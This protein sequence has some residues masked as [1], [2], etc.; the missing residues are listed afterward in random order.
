MVDSTK[1]FL[2]AIFIYRIYFYFW[3]LACLV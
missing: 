3:L 2:G 1:N